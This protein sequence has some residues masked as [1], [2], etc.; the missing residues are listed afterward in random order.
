MDCTRVEEAMGACLG[1]LCVTASKIVMMA[2][3]K[4]V[5]VMRNFVAV[6]QQVDRG[7]QI[8]SRFV[9]IHQ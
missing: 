1:T 5:C 7:P 9:T 3:T 4:P 6:L 2:P 8:V